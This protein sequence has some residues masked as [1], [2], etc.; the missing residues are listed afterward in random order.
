[1]LTDLAL[2]DAYRSDKNVVLRDFHVP[3]LSEATTYDR[4]AGYFTSASLSAASRGVSQL[5]QRGGRMRLVASPELTTQDI[6]A[7]RQ[8][9]DRRNVIQ[10]ALVRGITDEAIPNADRDR[11]GFLAWLIGERL[12]D[13]KIALVESEEGALGIYH[14][15]FGIFTDESGNQV[16]FS[17]SANESIGGLVSNFESIDV[18]RSWI[19]SDASRV[20]SRVDDFQALWTNK[21]ARLSVYD[22]PAAAE[23]ALLKHRPLRRPS[24]EPLQDSYAYGQPM[25]PTVPASLVLRD[26]QQEAVQAWFTSNGRG[27]FEMATGTGKTLTSLVAMTKLFEALQ[28]QGRPL[29]AVVV[30]PFKHLVDQWAVEIRRF[31]ASPILC[32][33]AKSSWFP[34]LQDA[35]A[36]QTGGQLPFAVAVTTNATFADDA[37]QSVMEDVAT[38]MLI[39]GDEAHN[40]G[41]AHTRSKLPAEASYRLALS[42]TPE[43]HHDSTGTDALFKYFGNPVFKIGLDE[44]IRRKVLTPYE[45]VPIPVLLDDEELG[46]YIELT[47]KIGQMMGTGATELSADDLSEGPLKMY[48][49]KRARLLGTAKGKLTTL[50]EIMGRLRDSQH[51]LVYCSDARQSTSTDDRPIRQIEA[52]VQIL[53]QDLEMHVNS[54]THETTTEMRSKLRRELASGELQALVA[55]RCLDEGVDIPEV[56]R[57]FILASSTNPRQFIQRR[58]RLLRKSQGKDSAE[59]Y[60]FIAVPPEAALDQSTF[61]IERRLVRRELERVVEFA[62]GASNREQA[63]A[64]L[65]DLRE[66]YHLMD[67]G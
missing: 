13:I 12:L 59:L 65:I 49:I 42:A 2:Q 46:E 55:I 53:G 33:E 52:V 56:R 4:A 36:A 38:D 29:L 27:T 34:Y 66:R 24:T 3:C 51:N 25:R 23:K 64:A 40:L 28:L 32:F 63:L 31:S 45:Y 8:G 30:C 37:F 54:Y 26:Y 35:I 11:L 7:I 5:I 58:G 15:K 19:E 48:L 1:M 20:A 9:Y 14:E 61:E 44:A 10:D 39:I 16:A 57:G 47:K 43:R 41:A 17:G 67:V 60:D 50:R 6:E 21:T 22:F 62:S 18:Y